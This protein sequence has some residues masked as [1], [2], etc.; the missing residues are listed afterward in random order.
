MRVDRHAVCAGEESV[1]STS[2][3]GGT[4][5]NEAVV[6]SDKGAIASSDAGDASHCIVGLE[7]A[8]KELKESAHAK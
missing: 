2:R 6:E 1:P 4:L 3:E 5:G 7:V 8:V